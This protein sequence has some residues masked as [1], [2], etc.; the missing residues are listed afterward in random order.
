[1]ARGRRSEQAERLS[2]HGADR[3]GGLPN[4]PGPL[5]G[6]A[7][8]QLCQGGGAQRRQTRHAPDPPGDFEAHQRGKGGRSL[9]R[10]G[11]WPGAAQDSWKH[12]PTATTPPKSSSPR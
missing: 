3:S 5:V 12:R 4:A 9:P 1:R 10:L 8:S 2:T 7:N 6:R 11:R